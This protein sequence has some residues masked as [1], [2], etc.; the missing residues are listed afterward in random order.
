VPRTLDLIFNPV[1][2]REGVDASRFPR[3]PNVFQSTMGTAGGCHGILL[4][5][6]EIFALY[7]DPCRERPPCKRT[8]YNNY[9][10][11]LPSVRIHPNA[12]SVPL[13]PLCRQHF[14]LCEQRFRRD[15]ARVVRV[16]R[17][18]SAIG[19]YSRGLVH[20]APRVGGLGRRP[21]CLDG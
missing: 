1:A 16:V 17:K 4:Q 20:R 18:T 13:L 6:L 14:E 10:H 21:V 7:L 15:K 3:P 2:G 12:T 11:G 8:F 19:A 5:C 9:A